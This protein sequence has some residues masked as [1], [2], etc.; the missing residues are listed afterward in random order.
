MTDSGSIPVVNP[1]ADKAR[2]REMLR[3][4]REAQGMSLDQLAARI[5]VP[6]VKLQS[7]E[8][9]RYGD[10]GDPN[11]VRALALTVCRALK[12]DPRV[13]ME[14]LPQARLAVLSDERGALNTPLPGTIGSA[15]WFDRRYRFNLAMLISSKWFAPAVFLM[16]ALA[17]YFWP[18]SVEWYKPLSEGQVSASQPLGASSGEPAS[19]SQPVVSRTE[20]SAS[21]QPMAAAEKASFADASA[22]DQSLNSAAMPQTE[23]QPGD[24][25]LS[26]TFTDQS[27]IEVMDASGA[28]LFSRIASSGEVVLLRGRSPLRLH[29]GNATA[30]QVN[31]NG[32]AVPLT[33]ISR[34]NTARLELK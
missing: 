9:D 5:K 21:Q 23:V 34:N 29:I 17:I 1:A 10:L 18:K 24:A 14:G 16:G 28:I 33:D 4:A 13:V 31:F 7:L 30:V 32:R 2:A 3:Q 27:W 19:A 8:N 11:L 15:G 22:S 6:A 26:L 25:S 12:I 20:D